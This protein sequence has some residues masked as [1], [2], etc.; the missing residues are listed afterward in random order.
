MERFITSKLPTFAQYPSLI[1]QLKAWTGLPLP[2]PLHQTR[3][4]A[5]SPTLRSSAELNLATEELS[6]LSSIASAIPLMP[7]AIAT[8]LPQPE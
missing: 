3:P 4:L 7:E 8:A 6:S 1:K 5:D 2:S